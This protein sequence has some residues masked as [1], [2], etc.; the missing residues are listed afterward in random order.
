MGVRMG[1]DSVQ[2]YVLQYNV[3][4][5]SSFSVQHGGDKVVSDD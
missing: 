2:R 3:A 5:N 4:S 1:I